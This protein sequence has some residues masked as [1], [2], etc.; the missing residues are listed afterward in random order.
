M[1][2]CCISPSTLS[3]CKKG[4]PLIVLRKPLVPGVVLKDVPPCVMPCPR[5][6][7]APAPP[8]PG[9]LD[10]V[11]SQLR[12]LPK[13][14]ELKIGLEGLKPSTSQRDLGV[15]APPS[16]ALS[17][18]QCWPASGCWEKM[19]PPGRQVWPPHLPTFHNQQLRCLETFWPLGTRK[20]KRSGADCFCFSSSLSPY[21]MP[22]A[23]SFFPRFIFF[24]Y[25]I[26][27]QP[28]SHSSGTTFFPPPSSLS[29]SLFL[30]TSLFIFLLIHNICFR[31]MT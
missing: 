17:T 6:D 15:S 25:F 20:R 13:R 18:P 31:F 9:P 29:S 30:P 19:G 10:Q 12:K 7:H 22:S 8:W 5:R 21:R 23:A 24:L 28:P 27:F 16:Q 14:E 4:P 26:T 2:I 11:P 3:L 1:S